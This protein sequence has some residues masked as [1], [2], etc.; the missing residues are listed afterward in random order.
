M[1]LLLILFLLHFKEVL[2]FDFVETCD[3]MTDALFMIHNISLYAYTTREHGMKIEHLLA[4]TKEEL[5]INAR[6]L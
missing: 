1:V 5:C 4:S 3:R 2:C 6:I